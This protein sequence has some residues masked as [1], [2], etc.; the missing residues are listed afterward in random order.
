[1]I[2]KVDSHLWRVVDGGVSLG[3]VSASRNPGGMIEMG[4]GVPEAYRCRGIAT[5]TAREALGWLRTHYFGEPIIALIRPWNPASLRVAEKLGMREYTRDDQN[6]TMLI[7]PAFVGTP[8]T[9][10][11]LTVVSDD[12]APTPAPSR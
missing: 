1:M 8:Q 11:G 3:W 4:W 7:G 12:P 5:R 6:V 2:E 10:A 9:Q